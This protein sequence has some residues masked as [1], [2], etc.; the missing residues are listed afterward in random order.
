MGLRSATDVDAPAILTWL[1]EREDELCDLLE[2][3]AEAESPSLEPVSQQAVFSLLAK[4]LRA[5]DFAVRNVRGFQ[6]GDHLYAR[7][8]RRRTDRRHQL[9]VGHMDTVWPLGTLSGMPVTRDHTVLS[10]P[11]VFDMKAGLAQLVFS[12]RALAEHNLD[13]AADPVILVTTDEE[14]GSV[15]SG[16]YVHRL[17]R[18][19][20]R[21]FV[22]EPAAG[23][24]GKLKIAR[25]GAGIF[26]VTVTGTPAH[27]GL[28]PERGAS[29]ILEL[30]HQIQRLFDLNDAERGVTVNVGNVDGGLRPN[31]VAPKASAVVDARVPTLAAAA[32]VEKAI[33]GLEPV[34]EGVS[35]EVEGSFGRPPM[36]AT[37]R[38]RALFERAQTLAAVLGFEVEEMAV[39]GASDGNTTSLYTATLDGLGAVGAGAH[40]HDE[41]VVI[42]SLPERAALLALLLVQPVSDDD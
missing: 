38:N 42:S 35:I 37:G 30:S 4:E 18:S 5:L 9:V 14:I 20:K 16:V 8:S 21:A 17:A 32:E 3:L 25:K 34:G 31:V 24:R 10:G 15:E 39:G 29:A 40:A 11:G 7:P 33:H 1:R 22:L 28:G 6:V 12:L 2:R 41:H 26:R 13:P 23:R 19:A 36:E 27:A